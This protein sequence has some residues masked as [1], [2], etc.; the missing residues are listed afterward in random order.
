MADLE[1]YAYAATDADPNRI[2]FGPLKGPDR[3]N[4]LTV[5][6]AQAITA[7]EYVVDTDD[8]MMLGLFWTSAAFEDVRA[9]WSVQGI[10]D[11]PLDLR[12]ELVRDEDFTVSQSWVQTMPA[13]PHTFSTPLVFHNAPEGKRRWRMRMH[14]SNGT[15]TIAEGLAR[16]FVSRRS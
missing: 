7:Q 8:T 14:T 1:Q 2:S 5:V 15:F 10:A 4:Q 6:L 12:V 9:G 11:E 3:G 13:G 16:W